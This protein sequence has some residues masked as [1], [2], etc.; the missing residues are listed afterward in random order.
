MKLVFTVLR[1]R[2]FFLPHQK[3]I[4]GTFGE[5]FSFFL[6]KSKLVK[7]FQLIFKASDRSDH[8]GPQAM[9]NTV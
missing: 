1:P 5:K 9:K 6:L 3:V 4:I 2:H 7:D 8:S